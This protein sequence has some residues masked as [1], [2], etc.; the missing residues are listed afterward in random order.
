MTRAYSR[1]A[2]ALMA[3]PL[4][5]GPLLAGWSDA[6]AGVAAVLIALTFLARIMAG[7]LPP[8]PE[9]PLPLTLM[10]LLLNQ[11]FLVLALYAAGLAL[12]WLGG[13]LALPLWLPLALTGLGAA[14]LILRHPADPDPHETVDLL[15]EALEDIDPPAPFEEREQTNAPDPEVVEATGRAIA[16]LWALPA[17]ARAE[18]CDD[19]VQELEDRTGPR[20]FPILLEEIG[21]GDP[22]VDRAMIRYL[23]RPPIRQWLVAEGADLRFAFDLLLQSG[24]PAIESDLVQ[25]IKTLLDEG[26]PVSALPTPETLRHRAE[27]LPAL[28]PLIARVTQ[29]TTTEADRDA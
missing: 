7:R 5:A 20:A 24:D 13:P 6:P 23:L 19:I 2:H 25:L 1:R 15:E 12:T 10:A 17:D 21:E 27:T 11:S 18:S 14:L 3:V 28:I 16:A 8:R 26:A 22:A 29:A 9:T 4:Y